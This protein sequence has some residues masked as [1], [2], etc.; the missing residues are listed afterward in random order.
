[1]REVITL[2]VGQCGN[3]MGG[4]FWKTICREHGI[5]AE[6]TMEDGRYL[7]DRKDIFFY[8]AD[9]G[10]FVPR[11][12]LIDLEPRVI[13]Q[14]S[15]LFNQ[16]NIFLASEGGGAGNNWAHGYCSG[17]GSRETVADIVQREAEG[18]DLLES[19]FLFHSI[20]GGTGSGFGSL[21]L[22]ELRDEFPKKIIQAYSIFPNNEDS[23]DVVVQP[24]NSTLALHRL[25]KCC[26]G[27]VVMDNYALGR[28]A[29]DSLRIQTPAHGYINNLISTVI[30]ASTSTTRFPGYM[31]SSQT[32][33]NACLVPFES[34]KFLVPSYTPFAC[35]DVSRI[36]R[37][38][39]CSDIMRRLLLPKTRLATYEE[40]KT[41]AVVSM[42]N[43]L[44]GIDD[45]QEVSKSIIRLMDKGQAS[46]VPWMPPSFNV[47]LNKRSAS[48]TDLS[49]VSGLALSNT[50]G[51]ASLLSKVA[52]QFDKLRRQKAF[53]DIYKRFDVSLEMFDESREMLTGVIDEYSR[54]ELSSYIQEE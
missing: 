17:K 51:I 49:R 18:C 6:G 39:T 4:E 22:E 36:V 10:K 41:Q 50:T 33:I 15:A 30:A 13:A 45:P 47:A 5:S 21:L 25:I 42:M 34:F 38:T 8:Q 23:S 20:A 1:M 24:Y 28:M 44:S 2:Q 54:A 16:E 14:A 3:Q 37:K 19:F 26:D 9:D 32:S 48:R 46:F 40:S 43:I 27:I 52:G 31:Y 29:L 35:E 12:V 53:V 11:A 7:G